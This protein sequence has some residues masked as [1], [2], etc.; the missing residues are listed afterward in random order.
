MK[1]LHDIQKRAHKMMDEGMVLLKK[2]IKE[3]EDLSGK[4]LDATRLHLE[5]GKD[6]LEHHRELG[7]LGSLCFKAFKPGTNSIN[8]SPEMK[9]VLDN[10]MR[11]QKKEAILGGKI[12]HLSIVK[13]GSSKTKGK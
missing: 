13:R 1:K 12:S 8:I 5:Y 6:R 7:K 11:L 3:A 4:A 2:G 10:V 9:R